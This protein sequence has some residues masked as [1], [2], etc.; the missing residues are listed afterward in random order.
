[1][2]ANFNVIEREVQKI[3][4]RNKL[5]QPFTE[6]VSNVSRGFSLF[7]RLS[8]RC[9]GPAAGRVLTLATG[10]KAAA[11]GF[12]LADWLTTELRRWSDNLPG[13][14]ARASGSGTCGSERPMT[15]PSFRRESRAPC[16]V[17]HP[18]L[19]V[20]VPLLRRRHPLV[21]TETPL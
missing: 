14:Q 13:T 3:Q 10:D 2:A 9:F 8:R 19:A 16:L 20:R 17:L 18:V 11:S 4:T 21:P 7:D 15:V 12:V 5:S 1:M 6:S